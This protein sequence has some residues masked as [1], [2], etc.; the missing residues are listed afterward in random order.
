MTDWGGG[1]D[2]VAQMIAGNDLLMPG[3]PNQAKA[4]AQAVKDGKLD[5]KIL[6]RNITR[7]LNILVQGPRFKGYKYSD[8]PD[9]KAHAEVTRQAAT[10]GMVLLKNTN[11]VITNL[12]SQ[13]GLLTSI[14]KKNMEDMVRQKD[15]CQFVLQPITI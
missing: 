5:V 6:D 11:Q 12:M 7:I 10:E 13:K 4:I 9:L 8:K 3:N 1:K 15:I 14:T 2:P